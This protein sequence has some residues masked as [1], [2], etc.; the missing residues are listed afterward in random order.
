MEL[1]V[2]CLH[3]FFEM[4]VYAGLALLLAVFIPVKIVAK[5]R[6]MRRSRVRITCRIC[7]YRFLR[8]DPE[9][10]CP[11]CLARNR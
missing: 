8:T 4:L 7:G 2:F 11:H 9:A 1:P 10:T 3:E 5:L 6:R